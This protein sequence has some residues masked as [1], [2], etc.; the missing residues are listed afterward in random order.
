[1]LPTR[2][3]ISTVAPQ[4]AVFPMRSCL[5]ARSHVRP[6]PGLCPWRSSETAAPS[7]QTSLAGEEIRVEPLLVSGHRTA[8]L[9]PK[10]R[11]G[12]DQYCWFDLLGAVRLMTRRSRTNSREYECH[13][14][15]PKLVRVGGDFRWLENLT[16]AVTLQVLHLSKALPDAVV[17]LQAIESLDSQQVFSYRRL[18]LGKDWPV[19]WLR[20]RNSEPCSSGLGSNRTKSHLCPGRSQTCAR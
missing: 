2:S 17:M 12:E 14:F 11:S 7:G 16:S 1:M 10:P 9:S 4:L 15:T 18:K 3:Y 8:S 5:S 19:I 20:S 6:F 13:G